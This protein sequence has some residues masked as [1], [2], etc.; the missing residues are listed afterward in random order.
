MESFLNSV[1]KSI[2]N[3]AGNNLENTIIVFPNQRPIIF[4][5]EELKKLLTPPIFMP[6]I[7]N[8]DNFVGEIS[9]LEIVDNTFLMF[10]LFRIHREIGNS[11]YKEFEEFIPFADMLL[12][13]FSEIDAYCVDAAQLFANI[14]ELKAIGE[15]DVSG[16]ELTEFQKKYL[17]FYKSLH[18]YYTK[19]KES[20]VRNKKAYPGMAYRKVAENINSY[21]D[22]LS[23]KKIYFVGFNA[24]NHCEEKIIKP[25]ID[26]GI[27]EII[28]DGDDYYFKDMNQE[29]GKFLRKLHSDGFIKDHEEYGT[30]FGKED[31]HIKVISCPENILQ[32]KKAGELLNEII[33]EEKKKDNNKE[34]ENENNLNDTAFVLADESLLIPVLNSLPEE[35][36]S[37]K[38][39]KKENKENGKKEKE[40]KNGKV[41]VTMGFPYQYSIVHNFVTALFNLH[42]NKRDDKFYYKDIINILSNTLVQD[43]TQAPTLKSIIHK[44]IYKQKDLYVSIGDISKIINTDFDK[45]EFLFSP[46]AS[47]PEGFLALCKDKLIPELLKIDQLATK[48]QVALSA[49]AKII[50]HF[51]DLSNKYNTQ[52]DKFV[53]VL[54]TLYKIYAKISRYHRLPFKGEPL[55]KLQ[56][57]G[58]LETRSLDFKNLF[59]LSANEN[60]LP[61]GKSIKSMI[62]INLKR[63]FGMRTYQENDSIFAYY[64]Y[65]L[66]QRSSNIYILYNSDSQ[67]DGKGDP[68]RFITQI[69][70]EL[71]PKYS[72]I[73]FVEEVLSVQ[74]TN[75]QSTF[76]DVE[77]NDE[78]MAQLKKVAEY[79]GFSPSSLNNYIKC[80]LKYYYENVL[81]IRETDK[82]TED[83]DSSELGNVIHEI[84]E[85]I[86]NRFK[87][88][89]AVISKE[90]LED[91]LQNLD[92]QINALE[93]IK[94]E[95]QGK[96]FLFREIA[97]EQIKAFIEKQIKEVKESPKGIIILEL[98]ETFKHYLEINGTKVLVKGQ[99]D[100]IDEVD[101]QCRIIDY[102]SGAVTDKDLEGSTVEED[103]TKLKEKWLQLMIYAWLYNRDKNHIPKHDSGKPVE[104]GI[105][106]LRN[107]SADLMKVKIV[108]DRTNHTNKITLEILDDIEAILHRLIGEILNPEIPF[109]KREGHAC[110][111]CQFRIKCNLYKQQ[112]EKSI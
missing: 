68:S 92:E 25:L 72:N 64:F 63:H 4:L 23:N 101:G 28:T 88:E 34:N 33:E 109:S 59:I 65:R 54:N 89:K 53:S 104:A 12:T 10:E 47:T 57:L 40:N 38:N 70:E 20:L 66:L 41:N 30:W 95:N 27:A 2:A 31:K 80:P 8:I 82:P 36:F 14:H 43:M 13:D 94:L 74:S 107:F 52:E 61:Q 99:I 6:K 48:E 77:K 32:A 56:I 81:G 100:R 111:Y 17:N 9:D 58:M 3:Q 29:A 93:K 1:A 98:E 22:T 19:L 50:N 83:I 105:Y 103:I 75:S 108:N 87:E 79:P 76:G 49:F 67:G 35:L 7:T 102:K 18:S 39:E 37:E 112:S 11:K 45:V 16:D 69:K 51:I 85:N 5:R 90:Y 55:E 71:V 110:L 44:D 60:R 73:K 96:G 62:P 15:W 26:S 46:E 21:I 78:I 84:L 42:I 86:F 106:P 24:L 97:K 91:C